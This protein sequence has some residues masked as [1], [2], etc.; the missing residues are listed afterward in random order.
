MSFSNFF[1]RLGCLRRKYHIEVDACVKRVYNHARKILMALK[2][3]IKA[4]VNRM[5]KMHMV[6]R[7]E[8]HTDWVSRA[9]DG[10]CCCKTTEDRVIIYD[11]KEL[12]NAIKRDKFSSPDPTEIRT[13][14]IF[15]KFDTT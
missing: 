7:P 11:P 12:D 2:Q 10:C 13:C 3:R 4:D 8:R 9:Y 15:T 6:K 14:E 1:Q 5:E